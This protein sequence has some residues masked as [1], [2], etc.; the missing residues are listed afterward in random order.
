M[1]V[2]LPSIEDGSIGIVKHLRKAL[3][4]KETNELD[5]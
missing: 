3:S 5:D 1:C 4:Q 2:D